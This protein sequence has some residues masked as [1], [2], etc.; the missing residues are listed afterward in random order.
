MR[1]NNIA[2]FDIPVIDLKRAVEFYS[3]LLDLEIK[4]ANDMY[5]RNRQE[6]LLKAKELLQVEINKGYYFVFV[7]R[8]F[9]CFINFHWLIFLASFGMSVI[10]TQ[11]NHAPL[12]S[13]SPKSKASSITSC[14]LSIP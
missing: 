4:I 8:Y 2:W 1:T 11:L 3:E 12:C 7:Y 5:L 9:V 14:V 6:E 10:N 13:I